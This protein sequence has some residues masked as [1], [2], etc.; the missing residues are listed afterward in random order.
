MTETTTPTEGEVIE[1][2]GVDETTLPVDD[3]TEDSAVE[4]GNDIV[5]GKQLNAG[6]RLNT[7]KSSGRGC[8]G[9]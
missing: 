5:T 2:T 9:N 6:G 3:G 8:F 7:C 1:N 4:T